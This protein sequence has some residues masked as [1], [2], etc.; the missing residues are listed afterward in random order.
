MGSD[1]DSRPEG[2]CL[3]RAFERLKSGLLHQNIPTR[4]I[5]LILSDQEKSSY[6]PCAV[7]DLSAIISQQPARLT[8]PSFRQPLFQPNLQI[9]QR[10][11][12]LTGSRSAGILINP[13][14]RTAPQQLLSKFPAR[15]EIYDHRLIVFVESNVHWIEIIVR[16]PRDRKCWIPA[17]GPRMQASR[18]SLRGSP[19]KLYCRMI[20]CFFSA[21]RCRRRLCLGR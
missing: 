15:P 16:V 8:H 21:M 19:S 12:I 18:L 13:A 1:S 10:S 4:S 6:H 7:N 3:G 9:P 14:W 17:R 20:S 5:F 11:R 2:S